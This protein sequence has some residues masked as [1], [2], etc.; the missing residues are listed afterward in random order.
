MEFQ[1]VYESLEEILKT[2]IIELIPKGLA[3]TL[4][5]NEKVVSSGPCEIYLIEKGSSNTVVKI[6]AA[7]SVVIK[8]EVIDDSFP[9]GG[10]RW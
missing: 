5:F 7:K 9:K 4:K 10:A 3:V 6:I 2:P 1:R 8:R